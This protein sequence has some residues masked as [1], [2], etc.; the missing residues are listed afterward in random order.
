M[1][2]YV[3]HAS[4]Y[5]DVF[6]AEK[7]KTIPF[8]TCFYFSKTAGLIL[9][10]RKGMICIIKSTIIYQMGIYQ[11]RYLNLKQCISPKLLYQYNK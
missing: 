8:K 7:G 10:F 5:V 6:S 3:F 4:K 2:K 1:H 9:A 11:R